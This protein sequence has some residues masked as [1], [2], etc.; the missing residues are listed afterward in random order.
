M[1]GE[2]LLLAGDVVPELPQLPPDLLLA[3]L[4]LHFGLLEGP[5]FRKEFGNTL[6]TVLLRFLGRLLGGDG[7]CGGVL[8]LVHGISPFGDW[9]VPPTHSLIEL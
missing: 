7:L 9:S 5:E 8:V 6:L 4:I 2:G 3:L 1:G